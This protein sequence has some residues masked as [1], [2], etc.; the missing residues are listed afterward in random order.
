MRCAEF[1]A[2]TRQSQ[3][4]LP[5]RRPA[6]SP[7]SL[8]RA[9]R[10]SHCVSG[11]ARLGWCRSPGSVWWF[12]RTAVPLAPCV[13]A[14]SPDAYP[15]GGLQV[16]SLSQRCTELWDRSLGDEEATRTRAIRRAGVRRDRG[17][18]ASPAQTPELAARYD[19][20]ETSS[21]LRRPSLN[22]AF[23]LCSTPTTLFIGCDRPAEKLDVSR[24]RRA[25]C[26]SR[27]STVLDVGDCWEEDAKGGAVS[28]ERPLRTRCEHARGPE[29][30]PSCS[31]VPA[32]RRP[33]RRA[34]RRTGSRTGSR[35]ARIRVSAV[36]KEASTW[37]RRGVRGSFIAYSRANADWR[38][39]FVQHLE[40]VVSDRT[41][42]VDRDSIPAGANWKQTISEAVHHAK[43]AL[44][45]STR[46]V[47]QEER[48]S[49]A[50][51]ASDS[52]RRRHKNG[53]L[54]LLPVLVEPC[55]WNTVPGLRDLRLVHWPGDGEMIAGRERTARS[56]KPTPSIAPSSRFCDRISREDFSGQDSDDDPTEDGASPR[57]SPTT[58]EPISSASFEERVLRPRSVHA[59]VR[60]TDTYR[61]TR[62]GLRR[63][64]RR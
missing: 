62:P 32:P 5:A 63:T 53:R 58:S 7:L 33:R 14:A 30:P 15:R 17:Y 20:D 11:T 31:T 47:P 38:D 21:L 44:L 49:P 23:T 60:G 48:N 52:S 35:G 45:L 2:P 19:R 50:L 56:P 4:P 61:E 36:A 12:P 55:S 41:L 18:I 3:Q 9:R 42:F 64:P 6:R 54:K 27:R 10:H 26:I 25:Q 13:L 29:R 28:Q 59:E 1:R 43:C 24:E 39:R 46:R 51:S 57:A 34:P 8:C 16:A 40:S 37:S 22:S